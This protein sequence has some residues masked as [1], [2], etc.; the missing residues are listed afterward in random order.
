MDE[1][2]KLAIQTIRKRLTYTGVQKKLSLDFDKNVHT[3][4]TVTDFM[5]TYILKPPDLRYPGMPELEDL[6]MKTARV[7]GIETAVHGLVKLKTGELAYLV[8]RFD[9][10]RLTKKRDVGLLKLHVE[11]MAQVT[12]KLTEDKYRSSMEKVGSAIYQFTTKKG[13]NV[14][15]FLDLTLHSFLIGNADMHLKNFSLIYEENGEISLSPAY[16]L[17]ATK[18]LMP[19]DEEEMALPIIGKKTKLMRDD[20]SSLGKYLKMENTFVRFE[21]AIPQ[22]CSLIDRSFLISKMKEGFKELLRSR[23][24]VLFTGP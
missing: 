3:R 9:R 4:L 22:M 11:D 18:L 24:A 10:K 19:G 12:G 21:K 15:R 7:C 23:S 20:F 5:G 2:E 17:L 16:D 6:S 14:S 1:I 13:W 8:R